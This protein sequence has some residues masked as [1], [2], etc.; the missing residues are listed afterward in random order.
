M[1][2]KYVQMDPGI[3]CPKSLTIPYEWVSHSHI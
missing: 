2:E 3:L 1:L